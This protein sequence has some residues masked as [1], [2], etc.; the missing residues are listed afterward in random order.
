[1]NPHGPWRQEP[2]EDRLFAAAREPS[3]IFVC[4]QIGASRRRLTEQHFG[5][6]WE[7]LPLFLQ[8]YDVTDIVFDGDNAHSVQRTAI[9]SHAGNWYLTGLAEGR[10]YMVDYG[11][12]TPEGRFFCLLRSAAVAT[13]PRMPEELFAPRA[14]FV[15]LRSGAPPRAARAAVSADFPETPYEHEF[16]GYSAVE[17]PVM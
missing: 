15:R 13:P 12:L 4:W 1:M 9:P 5:Q 11:L 7:R 2:R 6:P 14:R 17:R 10:S 8:A 16:D 3:A